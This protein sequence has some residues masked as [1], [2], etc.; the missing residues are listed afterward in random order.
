MRSWSATAWT[1]TSD[2]GGCR[3]SASSNPR[4]M[5]ETGD[6]GDQARPDVDSWWEACYTPV[7]ESRRLL[8]RPSHRSPSNLPPTS[9]YPFQSTT[10]E[11]PT[12]FR[13]RCLELRRGDHQWNLPN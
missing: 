8:P 1:T 13:P 5:A 2:T 3:S 7:K 9:V 11:D 12:R 10:A 4:S 6:Q